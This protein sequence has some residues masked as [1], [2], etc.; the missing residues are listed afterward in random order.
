MSMESH[1]FLY[2]TYLRRRALGVHVAS[3]A[4]CANYIPRPIMAASPARNRVAVMCS[5]AR[6]F[7]LHNPQMGCPCEGH[8]VSCIV[9]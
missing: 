3:G 6:A 8:K 1:P 5:H 2:D 7:M 4:V 9:C